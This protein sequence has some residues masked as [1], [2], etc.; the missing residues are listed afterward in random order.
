M[1]VI[2]LG[3]STKTN[4]AFYKTDGMGRDGY[5]TYN[6]GGFWKNSQIKLKDIYKPR[7][8]TIFFRSLF[9]QPAPFTYLS[10]GSGRD[11]YILEHNAGL[12]K[13]FEPL[14]LQKLPKFLR[15]NDDEFLFKHKLLLT[16]S[17]RRYLR[18]IKKIQ[19]EVV[20]RLYNDSLEKIKKK[21]LNSRNNSLNDLLINKE[22]IRSLT[23]IMSSMTDIQNNRNISLDKM[24]QIEK[25][26]FE[27]QNNTSMLNN[28]S[29]QK[30]LFE[31]IKNN[32]IYKDNSTHTFGLLNNNNRKIKVLKKIKINSQNSNILNGNNNGKINHTNDDIINEK[33]RNNNIMKSY[34][35]FSRN[36]PLRK[37]NKTRIF[38]NNSLGFSS[39]NDI[40]NVKY[41]FN[42]RK[43]N[44]K[45]DFWKKE[46]FSMN[47]MN[48]N[49]EFTYE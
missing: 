36:I 25:K 2:N 46:N 7:K 13:S 38:G 17:Q 22:K 37:I 48:K 3:R 27:K 34:N 1:S 40:G 21:Y 24:R 30:N 11:T 18:K 41:N 26:N 31:K 29:P 39:T 42:M 6:N 16:K 43:A 5:I 12:V 47:D 15:K 9:H 32:S 49:N 23:G 4:I 20:N 28:F 10:D 19:N 44:I 8:K 14:I 33:N 45:N 35:N